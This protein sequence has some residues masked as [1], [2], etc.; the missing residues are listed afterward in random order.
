MLSLMRHL[1]RFYYYKQNTDMFLKSVNAHC[2]IGLLGLHV[3][4]AESIV[5]ETNWNNWQYGTGTV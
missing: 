1:F 5:V 2:A 4:F 3:V